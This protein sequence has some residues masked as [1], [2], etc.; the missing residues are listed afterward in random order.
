LEGL[1][2][3]DLIVGEIDF[4]L[5]TVRRGEAEDSHFVSVHFLPQDVEACIFGGSY[6]LMV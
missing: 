6:N 1:L 4:D 2:E 3:K 5:R